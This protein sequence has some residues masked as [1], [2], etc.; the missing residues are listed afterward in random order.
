MSNVTAFL[1]FYLLLS[2]IS[3]PQMEEFRIAW[4]IKEIRERI[5]TIFMCS[6]I[7]IVALM[8]YDKILLV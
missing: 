8:S 1:L 4:R 5:I 6:V 3:L 2:L 7:V